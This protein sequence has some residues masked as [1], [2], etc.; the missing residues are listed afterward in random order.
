MVLVLALAL[1]PTIPTDVAA[2]N[3]REEITVNSL[4]A[5]PQVWTAWVVEEDACLAVDPQEDPMLTGSLEEDQVLSDLKCGHLLLSQL[6]L[7]LR[8]QTDET[9]YKS[10]DR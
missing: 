7:A 3:H 5:L 9:S 8:R 1:H 2:S 10:L 4:F 6:T